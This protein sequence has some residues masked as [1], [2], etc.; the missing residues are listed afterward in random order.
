[1]TSAGRRAARKSELGRWFLTPV[2]PVNLSIAIITAAMLPDA[3]QRA[4]QCFP[5]AIKTVQPA[6][7]A[8]AAA[9]T[10]PPAHTCRCISTAIA[11]RFISCVLFP[12]GSGASIC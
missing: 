1:M 9:A 8:A 5:L 2:N 4:L 6:G 11:D 3:G 7:R 12:R 10:P